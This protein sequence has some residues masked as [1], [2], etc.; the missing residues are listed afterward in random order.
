[1]VP[2]ALPETD[3]AIRGL[4]FDLDGVLVS[5]RA[6]HA[7][8]F[9]EVLAAYGI[10]DFQYEGFAGWRTA[11]VLRAVF[12]ERS[13]RIAEDDL[14]ACA[15]RKSARA[16]ELLAAQNP[17][18]PDCVPVVTQLSREYR[19]AL[20][21]SGSRAAVEAFLARTGLGPSF[22][23]VLCGDDVRRAKPD[24][25]I[26]RR[27]M[28]ALALEPRNCVVIEDAV[29]GI[30][31]ARSAGAR[32]IGFGSAREAQLRAAGAEQVV[33]SLAELGRLLGS[34]VT[35]APLAIDWDNWLQY[36]APQVDRARWT[37]II[38]AAG[39]GSRLAYG[40]PK[41]LFPVAGRPILE[42]LLDLLLPYCATVVFV[43]SP[44][45]RPD[46]EPELE[47]LAPGRCRIVIQPEPTGMGD[48]VQLGAAD[49]AT[50]HT[51]VIWGDQV[52]L[53]RASV[54]AVLRLHQGPLA[55]H[56]TVPTVLRPEPYIHF[57][58]DETGRIARLLQAREGDPMPRH[59]E[60]DAGFF[61][62]QT[63]VLRSLL[64]QIRQ[65]HAAR[66]GRTG[67]FNLLPIIPFAAGASYRV[68]TPRL[69]TL[70]ETVGINS[71]ADAS[72]VEPSLR[73]SNA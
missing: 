62:F 44:D 66:G 57:E 24:P 51:C 38:P 2:S 61:C 53:R 37:A 3:V 36:A 63:E 31:A 19:L 7:Q 11:D 46:V 39:K 17:V 12:A 30:Q 72:R 59:G 47:R 42:W 5:S 41:V 18:A 26:F 67:E 34:F 54:E 64:G 71:V 40:R 56:L 65:H 16:A 9:E 33:D 27:S 49:V 25:E 21:S 29:A 15:R 1:M 28:E 13:L 43:L 32:A 4:V 73:R 68:L 58:R 52:A 50:P 8:A 20:A 14:A 55:P 23:S 22:R 60:S 69:M 45:G 48:A 70:E 10:H 6:A 35:A